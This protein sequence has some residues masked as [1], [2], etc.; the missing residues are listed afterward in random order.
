MA[1]IF[2]RGLSSINIY[3][4]SFTI[5]LA[6][7][8]NTFFELKMMR[9]RRVWQEWNRHPPRES[10]R[11]RVKNQFHFWLDAEC[12]SC[13]TPLVTTPT[14]S[15]L[16]S[17]FSFSKNVLLL[18]KKRRAPFS[19][20]FFFFRFVMSLLRSCVSIAGYEKEEEE[21]KKG[22]GKKTRSVCPL[23]TSCS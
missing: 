15:F 11:L 21:W 1:H 5:C 7:F 23:S 18:A 12:S 2:W 16:F 13:I 8:L 4:K 22:K 6:S 19:S 17:F 9:V 10:E 20:T 14:S 3:I